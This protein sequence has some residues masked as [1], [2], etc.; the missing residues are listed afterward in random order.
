MPASERA[1]VGASGDSLAPLA[2]LDERPAGNGD[3]EKGSPL[4]RQWGPDADSVKKSEASRWATGGSLR[5]TPSPVTFF[6]R[7]TELGAGRGPL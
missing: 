1:F 7:L 2:V 6:A 5:M 4:P 3:L